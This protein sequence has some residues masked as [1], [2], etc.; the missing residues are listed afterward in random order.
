MRGGQTTSI[1]FDPYTNSFYVG[2]HLKNFNTKHLFAKRIFKE[3][4]PQTNLVSQPHILAAK[5]ANQVLAE[6]EIANAENISH[7]NLV[8]LFN[9][10]GGDAQKY[11][12]LEQA[13]TPH[14]LE[15]LNGRETFK[16]VKSSVK[17]IK[18]LQESTAEDVKYTEVKYEIDSKL[19]DKSYVPVE[20]ML[21]S[22]IGGGPKTQNL[23]N[24]EWDFSYSRNLE[25]LEA[26]K[27]ITNSETGGSGLTPLTDPD[28]IPTGKLFNTHRTIR[29]INQACIT[30]LKKFQM[31]ITTIVM[32]NLTINK[33]TENFWTKGSALE[34]EPQ[35]PNAGV[36]V[37][38]PGLIGVTAVVDVNVPDEAIWCLTK[39]AL[40]RL[41]GPTIM[42]QYYD[43][44]RN[45]EVV[46]RLDYVD[47]KA[48]DGNSNLKHSEIGNRYFSFKMSVG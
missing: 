22:T 4:K 41:D 7:L 1:T 24:M 27:T 11:W 5:S 33:L 12:V 44:E 29:Q 46:K 8:R 19:S 30:F 36:I 48:T 35:R 20:D 37:P 6:N 40:R 31:P 34:I 13:F 25:A 17:R 38:M 21:K 14:P 32:N 16:G 45:A 43:E 47:W 42:R 9:K 18:R 39:D 28:E 10:V 3:G 15:N 26:I 23:L 2:E